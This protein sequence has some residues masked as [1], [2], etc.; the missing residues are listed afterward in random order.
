[1]KNV[2]PVRR[3]LGVKTFFNMLGP[4]V[5]PSFPKNQMVGVFSLELARIY[6]YLYQQTDKN[7]VIVH[8]LDGYD[9]ISLTGP[10]KAIS[11]TE[12]RIV[13]ASDLGLKE[14][15]AEDLFGGDTVPAA[16]KIFVDVLEGKGTA[17]QNN[18]VVANA[19]MAL[20]CLHPDKSQADC[21][22]MAKESLIGKKA[23]NT[24]TKLIGDKK[25]I[26]AV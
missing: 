2:A 16:A 7:Y 6:N 10:F 23:Y 4:M 15:N 21:I 19:G 26:I 24:F 11:N 13:Q 22:A 5:N 9:E 8:S 1:M 18:V 20:K 3:Q 17:V 25:T 14:V 12:E